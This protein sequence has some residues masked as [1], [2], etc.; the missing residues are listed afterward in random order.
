MYGWNEIPWRKLEK[1]VY[2]LQQRIYQASLRGEVQ[3]VHKL[4]RL[5]MKSWSAKCLAV[6]RVTARQ[7]REKNC[8]S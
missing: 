1:V 2:K 5:M 7:S 4:Q 3:K 6:R 8:R